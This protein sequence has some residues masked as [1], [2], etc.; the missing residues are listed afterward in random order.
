MRYDECPVCGG[1]AERKRVPNEGITFV[2]C[3]GA[4]RAVFSV[5]WQLLPILD[6]ARE[7][8]GALAADLNLLA[9]CLRTGAL[10]DL[11]TLDQVLRELDARRPR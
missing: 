1:A 4:C 8:Q 6:R 5:S 9:V 2:K 10:R 3:Q 7:G 11:L